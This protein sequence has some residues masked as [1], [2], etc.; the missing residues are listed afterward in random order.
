MRFQDEM[1]H[2]FFLN[3]NALRSE[4]VNNNSYHN[5]QNNVKLKRI[6]YHTRQSLIYIL[7]EK[8]SSNIRYLRLNV[9]E[10]THKAIRNNTV[11]KNTTEL[12]LFLHKNTTNLV[13]LWHNMS[14]KCFKVLKIKNS[15]QYK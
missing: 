12:V 6:F 7:R 14:Q 11:A 10:I 15:Y 1:A 9:T 13:F 3:N 8:K 5:Y 2:L 4:S